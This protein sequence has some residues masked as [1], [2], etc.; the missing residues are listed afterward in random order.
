MKLYLSADIEGTAGIT[1]WDETE[2][3]HPRYAYFSDQMTREVR[4]ACEGAASAGFGDILVK[5]AH[6]SACNL[7]P[8]K[9]PASENLRIFRGW[10]SDIHSMMSGIDASF[11]GAIFTGYHSSSN[12]DASPLCHT[13]NLD[14][15]S[16]R[17][18]GI[19]A[20]ELVINTFA[21]ALYDVP[22]L[23]VTGDLGVCE[24]AKRLCPAIYTVPVSRGCGNGSIS[25]H[26]A[27]AVKRIRE[28]AEMAVA[29]GI[30]HPEKFAVAL[31]N[32][33]DV[34]VEFVKHNRARRASFYPGVKQIGPRTVRF[35]SDAYYDVLRFFMFCL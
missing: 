32:N 24:Q 30:A 26:P 12:T 29:D 19:Q 20:S 11:A 18:N 1:L 22:V 14:N 2:Y 16:I 25:I 7:I 5:D 3:G 17:I 23:L 31:P 35:S 15:V 27:E 8:A 4:A 28:K 9:L 10:G 13:M 34:E 33:F 6:D 21:A